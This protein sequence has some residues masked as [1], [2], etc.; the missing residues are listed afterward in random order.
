MIVNVAVRLAVTSRLKCKYTFVT[1]YLTLRHRCKCWIRVYT[2]KYE[3]NSDPF[4]LGSFQLMLYNTVGGHRRY[5]IGIFSYAY[6]YV[7]A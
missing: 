4:F 1:I 2:G 6:T 5:V 7:S 3:W